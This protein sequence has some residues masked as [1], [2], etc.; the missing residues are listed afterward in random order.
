MPGPGRGGAG[1]QQEA[2]LF[3]TAQTFLGLC[4][5][6]AVCS[7]VWVPTHGEDSQDLWSWPGSSK[8]KQAGRDAHAQIGLQ[9]NAAL[10]KHPGT[11]EGVPSQ[12]SAFPEEVA[13]RLRPPGGQ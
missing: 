10:G 6:Q 4:R 1:A 13:L 2:H 8:T 7:R 3:L 11:H 5:V 12:G 9:L